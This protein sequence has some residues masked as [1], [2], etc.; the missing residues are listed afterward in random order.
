MKF[1]SV[2]YD[3]EADVLYVQLAA[4]AVHA[5]LSLGDLRMIDEASDGAVLGVEFVGASDGI[6]LSNVPFA[7]TIA[8]AIGDSGLPL[9]VYA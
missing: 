1:P 3:E 7:D 8:A 5:T 9:R 6:D 2:S 4:G